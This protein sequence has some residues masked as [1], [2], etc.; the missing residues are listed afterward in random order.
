MPGTLN[1][2]TLSGNSASRGGGA[3]S[4]ALNNCTLTGNSARQYGGGVSGGTLN[5]CIVY[6]N[7]APNESNYSS[8]TLDYCC[9]TPLPTN[10]AG[11]ITADPQLASASHLSAS[12]ALPRGGQRRLRERHWTLTAKPWATPPSIGCDEYHSGSVTGALTVAILAAHTNVAVGFAV[13]FQA[14]ISGR[15]SASRWEFGDGIV[16]SNRPYASHA[17]SAPAQYAVVLTAYNESHPGGVSATVTVQVATAPVQYVAANSTNPVPPYTSWA[18]AATNIQEAVDAAYLGGT[19]LVSDGLYATG[20][21]AVYGTMANRVAVDKPLV[22]R[23]V[24]GPQF[25]VIEG[26]QVPGTTNGNAAIRCVYLTNGA[27]LSGFTLTHGATWTNGDY[28][29]DQSGGGVWCESTNAFVTNCV[30]AG[31]SAILAGR[32]SLGTLNNCTLTGNSAAWRWGVC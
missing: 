27:S 16:V 18:T 4:G 11:N 12:F 3:Y 21:R 9:T 23:S 32:R 15:V 24:N 14:L 8:S 2:C 30:M 6:F 17:W 31:N 22:L 7:T 10:G 20:G 5:N 1:N 25:T 26:Y 13:D 19:V 28:F 29:L